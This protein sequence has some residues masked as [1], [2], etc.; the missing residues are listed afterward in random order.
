MVGNN[1]DQR[2]CQQARVALAQMAVAPSGQPVAWASASGSS[3]S[4]TPTQTAFVAADGR[5]CRSFVGTIAI[6]NRSPVRDS[7]TV[8]RNAQGDYERV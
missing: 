6:Q 4:Y 8:C 2:D 7:G 1:L 3:G 5:M